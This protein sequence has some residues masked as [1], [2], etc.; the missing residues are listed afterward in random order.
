MENYGLYVVTS[1]MEHH[2][3]QIS[4]K[5]KM[6]LLFETNKKE[7]EKLKSFQKFLE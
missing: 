2:L 7:T 6:K 5:R 1:K 4:G 3:S